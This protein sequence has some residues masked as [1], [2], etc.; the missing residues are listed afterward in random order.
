MNSKKRTLAL[1]LAAL[2]LL[3]AVS[4]GSGNGAETGDGTKPD[5]SSDVTTEAPA[6]KYEFTKEFDGRTINVMN[7][8]DP[9]TSHSKIYPENEDGEPLNDTEY[10][11]VRKLEEEMGIT[12][13]ETNVHHDDYISKVGNILASA[14]D[15]Y[16]IVYVNNSALYKFA[17]SG[18][19][20]NLLDA[21]RLSLQSD[22]WIHENNDLLAVNGK[23]YS[24]EGYS[25]LTVVDFINIMMYNETLGEKVG[26]DAPYDLVKEGKWTLD[27]FS[28][29]LKSAASLN[30]GTDADDSDNIWTFDQPGNGAACSGLMVSAGEMIVSCDS[31]KLV[32][33]AGSERFMNICEKI[34]SVMTSNKGVMFTK[35]QYGVGTV[36]KTGQALLAYGE[37]A[38]TVGLREAEFAFGVLPNPKY[39]ETQERYYSRKSWPSAA[40]AIPTA[41]KDAECSAAVVDALTFL[42]YDMVWPVYRGKVLEQKQLRND[43]SIE[44]LDII[45]KSSAPDL[46]TIFNTGGGD[47]MNSVGAR[48]MKGDGSVA[49]L[50]ES[51]RGKIVEKINTINSEY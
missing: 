16:D 4:C 15:E 19:L 44:M 28:E 17:T 35:E 48:L 43:E 37:I 6:A 38:G 40:A 29:Y 26:L 11:A 23:L 39:D 24:A 5:V 34:A 32:F 36:F 20:I 50:V 14:D 9:W 7:Y 51:R 10:K 18:Y 41:A 8:E 27:A 12:F 21:D 47:L 13:V 33:D 22:W 42:F 25:N 49:S 3:G 46:S 30:L 31:G 1:I 45:L 2:T